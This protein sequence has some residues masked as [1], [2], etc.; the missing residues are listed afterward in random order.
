MS[1][2]LL[3]NALMLGLINGAFYALLSMGLALIFGLLNVVNFAHGALFMLGGYIAWTLLNY[4]G[5]GYWPSLIFAPLLVAVLAVVIEVAFLRRLYQLDHLYGLLLT[6]GVGLIIEGLAHNLYGSAGLPF[7]VPAELTGVVRA[8]PL[9]VPIYRLWVLS[10][11]MV[12]CIAIWLLVEKT[13]LGAILRAST[14]DASLVS[15]FGINVPIL[16]TA[17]YAGGAALA[18]FCGVLA[19]PVYSLSPS[20]GAAFLTSVFA[21]VVVG[22]MGSIVGA[23]VAGFGL[24]MIEGLTK[25]FYPAGSSISIFVAMAL[26][27]LMRPRGLFGKAS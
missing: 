6:F 22:G 27:L 8:G 20:M 19:A 24:G 26:V 10:L 2:I 12:M 16:V 13:R 17:T 14:Q 5:V 4:L 3:L 9:V 7:P 25:I 11:S 1:T 18:A 23:V 21:V 15:A